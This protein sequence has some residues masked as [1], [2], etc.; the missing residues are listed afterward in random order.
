MDRQHKVW[1]ERWLIRVDSTHAV[2]FLKID[3]GF[4][5]SWHSHQTKYNL[6]VVLKGSLTITT[7]EIG[8]VRK[9]VTL[10]VGECF[11]VRPGQLHKFSANVDAEVVE[12]MYVQYDEGDINRVVSGG[13]L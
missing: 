4:Q 13:K 9:R 3:S 12:E 8:G 6:F 2:S 5:C 10:G 1:G 7:E 11:T